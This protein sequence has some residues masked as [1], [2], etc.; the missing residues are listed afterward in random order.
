MWNLGSTYAVHDRTYLYD[1]PYAS[2]TAHTVSQGYDG[3]YSHKGRNLFAIDFLMPEGAAVCAARP[4]LVMEIREDSNEGGSSDAY[5]DKANYVRML[6]EDG[7]IADYWHIR[8]IGALVD[9][10]QTV[11]RGPTITLSGDTGRSLGPHLHFRV[12]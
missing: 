11:E 6:Q 4:G 10:G 1:L 12:M 5:S 2:G 7:T 3:E 8:R 9:I